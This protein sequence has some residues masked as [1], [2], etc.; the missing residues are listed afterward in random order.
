MDAEKKVMGRIINRD[1]AQR[2]RIKTEIEK[3]GE[4]RIKG[5]INR[6][7]ITCVGRE[8]IKQ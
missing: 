8:A 4:R 6:G 5:E 7:R 1:R 3:E 2:K